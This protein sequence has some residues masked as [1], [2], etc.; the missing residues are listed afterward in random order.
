[1]T[2]LDPDLTSPNLTVPPQLRQSMAQRC[3][4]WVL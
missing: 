4:R 1:M 2:A 3:R